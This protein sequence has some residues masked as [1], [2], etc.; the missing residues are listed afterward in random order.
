MEHT[1]QGI[2]QS[3]STLQAIIKV[4][5]DEMLCNNEDSFVNAVLNEEQSLSKEG[6]LDNTKDQYDIINKLKNIY[7][8]INSKVEELTEE[9]S[10][11]DKVDESTIINSKLVIIKVKLH[12]QK[13][14]FA[15]CSRCL[16][17]HSFSRHSHY[18]SC[19]SS[20]RDDKPSLEFND[21]KPA[22]WEKYHCTVLMNEKMKCIKCGDPF[23]FC[24][25]SG[26]LVCKNCKFESDP[27][28]IEWI[29]LVCKSEFCCKA[30]VFEENDISD[31]K[32]S[33]QSTI[34]AKILAKPQSVP[35]CNLKVSS[36]KFL[37]KEQCSGIIYLGSYEG[38]KITVCEKCKGV[39]FY[40]KHIW[41]C[42]KCKKRFRIDGESTTSHNTKISS[43]NSYIRP[44]L[45]KNSSITMRGNKIPKIIRPV[46][47][48]SSDTFSRIVNGDNLSN[49]INRPHRA[50][51]LIEILQ[52]RKGK[53]S[54][55]EELLNLN[56]NNSNCGTSL[57]KSKGESC[58]NSQFCSTAVSMHIQAG[59]VLD[60]G[61]IAESERSDLGSFVV[62]NYEIIDQIGQ[63]SYGKIYKVADKEDGTLM[64]MKKVV[65]WNE[66]EVH[67]VKSECSLLAE[68]THSNILKIFG[69]HLDESQSETKILYILTELANTD[70]DKEIR[71]KR[72][73]KL[74]YTETELIEI[75]K[76]LVTCLSYLEKMNISHR[77]IKPQNVLIFKNNIFKLADF[78]DAKEINEDETKFT[79]RGTELYMSPILFSSYKEKK[80]LIEHNCFKSDVFS[81]G[82][83]IIYAATLS[84]K[85]VYDIREATNNKRITLTVDNYLTRYSH[86]FRCLLKRM[87]SFSED[88]RF[89]FGEI[90]EYLSLNF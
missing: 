85:Y 78:G 21:L 19:C 41:T 1:N 5:M 82:L 37:H 9:P 15:L 45:N 71:S 88:E 22:T 18:N 26:N 2:C 12:D 33:I 40:E 13:N 75:L 23:Y 63:G 86:Q 39:N 62:E 52:S 16:S 24:T 87:L 79:L 47:I 20:K 17:I 77:D 29:C 51:T 11:I 61:N 70:W 4:L 60:E 90:E 49:V 53:A 35:C 72:S 42:P 83:C 73:E 80:K 67:K 48:E 59:K 69:M 46:K 14:K 38:R 50:K 64:A 7:F 32:G 6:I 66:K 74:Y 68:F 84:Y 30:K 55:S 8:K 65:V 58:L 89:N 44:E 54:S 25:K 27:L 31:V 10:E 28:S 81:L 3:N 56:K 76:Q 43:N 36:T 57:N 34:E